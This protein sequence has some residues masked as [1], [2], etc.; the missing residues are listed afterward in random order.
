LKVAV[1]GATGTIG[2][3]LVAA[4]LD[5][6][7]QVAV[8]SRNP[9]KAREALGPGVDAH[10]WPDPESQPAPAE[11]L[12]DADAVVHLAGEPVDQRWSDEA[13]RRIRESRELGT[14]NLVAGM[15]AGGPRLRTLVSASAAGYYGP[16]GDER[17]TEDDEP[18]DDFLADVVT[19]W[20]REAAKAEE[21][22]IRVVMLRTGIVL[23]GEGGALGRMLTPFKLGVGGPVAGGRQYMP[24]VHADDVVGA[25]QFALDHEEASGPVN[26]SAPEPVTNREFSRALGK[27][28]R[29]PAFAPVPALAIKALYGE[30]ATI[31]T[32]GVRMMPARL[33]QLGYE[34]RH[35]DLG[36]A[37]EAAVGQGDA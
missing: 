3:A 24:W 27:T 13:K 32:G 12:A 26:L 33:Q 34:F 2:R 20:E 7:D 14:R 31:V 22:G 6:G 37:L 35:P 10:A 36:E 29:R 30:M 28:L 18:G 11:A 17:V 16:R 19:R 9:D 15:K 25:Y 1:T 8:L 5:R 21:H 4:L 23:S